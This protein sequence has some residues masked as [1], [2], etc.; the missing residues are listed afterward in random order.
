[1]FPA[2]GEKLADFLFPPS[3]VACGQAG[4]W[5]CADCRDGCQRISGKIC[6]KCL[7]VVQPLTLPR[8]RPAGPLPPLPIRHPE[9]DSGSPHFEWRPQ[10]SQG[11]PREGQVESPT[12]GCGGTLPFDQV[13]ALGYY[14]DPKLR[15]V[16]TALKFQG[17]EA[18]W[19]SL[20]SF[21]EG[22]AEAI[23]V[24][25]D[26]QAALVPMPLSARRLKERGFNQAEF[27]AQALQERLFPG[28]PIADCLRR[29][30]HAAPQS[31]LAHD[32]GARRV[33]IENAFQASVRP[34]RRVIL[35]DDVITTGATAAEAASALSAAGAERVSV[36]CLA[37]GS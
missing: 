33:N 35:V 37:I 22:H 3:C 23:N 15:P 29:T 21:L 9:L 25:G 36:F 12:H 19:K 13:W 34:P 6:P 20:L 26:G 1:M 16:I 32:L 18:L 17:V 27:V 11:R 4:D 31:S 24:P 28:S 10:W 30:V 8:S 2:I 7:A 14:H 5:W